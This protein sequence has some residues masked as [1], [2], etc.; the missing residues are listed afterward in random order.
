MVGLKTTPKTLKKAEMDVPR[1]DEN[2]DKKTD[3]EFGSAG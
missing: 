1:R 2:I 3:C